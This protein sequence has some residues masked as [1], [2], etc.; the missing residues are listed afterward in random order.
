MEN[1]FSNLVY[2]VSLSSRNPDGWDISFIDVVEKRNRYFY[3]IR[4][5]WPDPPNYMGFR[6]RGKLQ[7]IRRVKSYAIVNNPRQAVAD[8]PDLDW[9]PHYVLTLGPAIVPSREVKAGPR[10]IRSNR[11]WCMIDALLTSATISDAL[12]ETEKRR[13]AQDAS[14]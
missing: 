3:P 10:V 2:V 9:G 5:G 6:Y 13:K 7:S 11:C 1:K 8:W 14:A 4:K 12:T